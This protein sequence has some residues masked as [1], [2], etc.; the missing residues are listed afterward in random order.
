M[1]KFAR[2]LAIALVLV[3]ALTTLVA[4][5]EPPVDGEKTKY[6]LTVWG[7]EEDQAMLK[8]M[9]DA[10]AKANPQN[11]YKFLF[12][13]QSEADA[14]DK[15]LNDVESGPDVYSFASDQI[16]KLFAAGALARVGG[17]TEKNV[18]ANNTPGSIDAASFKINGEDQLWAYPMTGDN[19]YFVYY[20]K[21]VFTEE[22]LLASLDSMLDLKGAT[23]LYYRINRTATRKRVISVAPCS[24]PSDE[25]TFASAASGG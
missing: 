22:S 14:A 7:A 8:A 5:P 16:N 11:E 4:C 1:K 3:M 20:D 9:C 12:G 19:C 17:E 25:G 2:I 23:E 18:I 21:R 24:A 10:Y 6:T 13:V 15:V